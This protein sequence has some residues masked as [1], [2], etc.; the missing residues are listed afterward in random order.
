[1]SNI[2]ILPIIIPIV[3]GILS[4]K[5]V[6]NYRFPIIGLIVLIGITFY[7][8]IQSMTAPILLNLGGHKMPFGI[9]LYGDFVSLLL[10]LVSTVVIAM[11]LYYQSLNE[12]LQQKVPF[13]LFILAGINGSYLTADIFN[14]F[15]M[16]EVMLLASFILIVIEKKG[17]QFKASIIYVILNLIGSWLFLIAIGILYS[18][19]GTLNFAHLA[20]RFSEVGYIPEHRIIVILFLIV[21][22]LKSALLIFIWLPR[23]YGVLSFELGAIFAS[24][25]TK[26]GVY[27]IYRSMT[28]I[29]VPYQEMMQPILIWMSII[30]IISGVLG[31]IKHTDM[32]LMF[33]YQ[34]IISIGIL[35]FGIATF[36]AQGLVG[37]ILYLSND[38][39]V[40]ASLFLIGG[41]IV[42]TLGVINFTKHQG[43]YKTV[44]KTAFIFLFI[45]FSIGGMPFTGGFPGKL[46]I[47]QAGIAQGFYF[48]TTIVVIGTFVGMYAIM[49]LFIYLF[50]GKAEMIVVKDRRYNKK[51]TVITMLLVLSLSFIFIS[52]LMTQQIEQIHHEN[53]IQYAKKAGE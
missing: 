45:V 35:C 42:E 44:T 16:F 49:K 52:G 36:H 25:L 24:L 30:T 1:M 9:Q 18:S 51:L 33:C 26:V 21:F 12:S 38:I 40:K 11:V 19:Y 3:L 15:V 14:L 17:A 20:E 4:F 29:F 23:T 31:V 6:K 48:S 53:Y 28:I 50:L 32:K 47:V 13:I 37:S 46:M 7:L 10:I 5:V 41:L 22:S 2:I 34:V 8:L 27:A 39:L 43:L